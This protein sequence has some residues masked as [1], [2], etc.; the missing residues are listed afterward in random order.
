MSPPT[1][2]IF[3]PVHKHLQVN[4]S[5]VYGQ[6]WTPGVAPCCARRLPSPVLVKQQQRKISTLE[7]IALLLVGRL[8]FY[9]VGSFD[10]WTGSV[11][12]PMSNVEDPERVKKNLSVIAQKRQS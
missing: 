11:N 2:A 10:D 8:A 3:K 12:T 1:C 9:A 6:I 7:S 5:G 4:A